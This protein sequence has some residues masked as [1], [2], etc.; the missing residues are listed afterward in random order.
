MIRNFDT[1]VESITLLRRLGSQVALDDFG[2]G[3][4]SLGYLHRLPID[5]VKID[6]SFVAGLENVSGRKIVA[7][8]QGLC[9]TLDI[10][11]IVEGVENAEQLRV[12]SALG[13]EAY[14]AISS[15][16]RADGRADRL[17]RRAHAGCA[18]R[19]LAPR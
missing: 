9:R 13:C 16:V 14:Q 15:R 8:I 4:S 18:A 12:L 3:Q 17:D 2:T 5:E 6:R 7:S 19:R 1:A 11:C 10:E